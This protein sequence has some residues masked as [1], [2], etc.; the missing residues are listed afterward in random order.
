MK[1]ITYT[2]YGGPDVLAVS[3]VPK[4]EPGDDELLVRVRAAEATKSD[5]ELRSFRFSVSWFWLPLR[6]AVGVFRP[7]RQVLG[8]YFAGEVVEV[9]ANVSRFS[10]GDDVFGAVG[11]RMG[12]YGE[13]VAVPETGTITRKPSNMRFEDAAAVPLG[14]LNA[15]HFMRLANIEGGESVLVIGAGGS[16]GLHGVQIARAKGA[17]VTAVDKALKEDLVRR[18]GADHF[19]DYTR[20][21]FQDRDEK[22][23]V[24]FDMVPTSSFSAC[25]SVL[26]PGGC[27]FTGNPRLSVMLRCLWTTKFTDKSASFAFARESL[28]EL[29]ALREMIEAGQVRSI[30]DAVLPMEEVADAHR[31]V[32]DETRLGAI[33]LAIG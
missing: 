20:E 2:R 1:A 28:E 17:E 30:V 10:P 14:G 4:P 21:R 8:V 29:E 12:A 5:C 13:Y 19:I 15:L 3:E 27:Y 24:V 25:M 26:K 33:V 7:R 18:M 32:E 9:G 22:Y 6:L 11:L 31:R 23:D 16:I